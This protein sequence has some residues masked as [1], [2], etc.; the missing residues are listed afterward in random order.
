MAA[1][2]ASRVY[3]LAAD[4]GG[5]GFIE[6]NK[7]LCMLSVLINTHMLMAAR[8]ARR[9]A[10]LLRLVG[11]CLRRRAPDVA[12]RH[13]ARARRTPT[14]RCPRTGTAGRS[15]SASG[16]AGTSARTSGSRRGWRATTTSTGRYGTWDGGREK[17]P[18]AICRKVIEA[19]APGDHA[20][21]DLGRRRAD[22]EL[23]VHRRL[24][25]RHPAIMTD[26]DILD[27]INLGSRTG[28]DQR[29]GR[30]RRGHRRDRA[31]SQ[32]QPRRAAGRPRAQQRQHA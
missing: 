5:M 12:R 2:G 7:A 25:V 11:L 14:P 16:C 22:P 28:H 6:N 17:A 20:D 15:S 30:H 1:A 9:R 21:R 26:S 8:E 18:A 31:G 27:P 32:L 13:R 24:R 19:Q 23:H 10:V 3:N 4:M 29:A